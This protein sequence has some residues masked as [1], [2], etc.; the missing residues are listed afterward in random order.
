MHLI[1]DL[2]SAASAG[3]GCWSAWPPMTDEPDAGAGSPHGQRQ[4]SA[5]SAQT[6]SEVDRPGPA[7]AAASAGAK[8]DCSASARRGGEQAPQVWRC[9]LPDGGLLD[10]GDRHRSRG[11]KMEHNADAAGD[12]AIAVLPT[13]DAPRADTEQ[14]GDA[15]L[16]DA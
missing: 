8:A 1:D 15:L 12:T 7:R 10:L 14:P 16:C 9:R 4:T 13:S 3:Y 2:S 5:A 6:F 11:Q